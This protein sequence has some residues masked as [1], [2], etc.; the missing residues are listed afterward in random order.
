MGACGRRG[1]G[2]ITHENVYTVVNVQ[3]IKSF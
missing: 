2:D 1:G 3:P